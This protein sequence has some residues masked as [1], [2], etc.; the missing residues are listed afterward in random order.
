M[1][2]TNILFSFGGRLNR[3]KYWL[4]VLV[5]VIVWLAFVIVTVTI[6]GLDSLDGMGSLEGMDSLYVFG[7]ADA[8]VALLGVAA[9][10]FSFWTG[11]A[12]AI[13]RLHD[14]EKSG[15]W[16][17]VFWVLPGVLNAASAF[18]ADIPAIA[19][20]IA[21]VGISIWGFVE[22]ACLKG[23]AGPNAYGPDPL[24]AAA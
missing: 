15:W 20:A 3:G 14:R 1:D 7:G 2:W 24:P 9:I 22:I 8:V 17:L 23:T 6:G 21:S 4:V 5:N 19:L 11:F 12:T 18:V 16:I 13:K 10:V